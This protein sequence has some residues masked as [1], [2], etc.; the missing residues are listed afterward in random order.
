MHRHPL[1]HG[2]PGLAQP[3]AG[4][5]SGYLPRDHQLI[6]ETCEVRPAARHQPGV[7]AQLFLL[8]SQN[9]CFVAQE[10][11]AN[12]KLR[13][14]VLLSVLREDPSEVKEQE[15]LLGL[16]QQPHQDYE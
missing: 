14:F 6:Q 5:R 3:T 11:C 13:R 8:P 2:E 16:H 10:Q 7:C 1:V 4:K 9:E 12:Q 15:Q